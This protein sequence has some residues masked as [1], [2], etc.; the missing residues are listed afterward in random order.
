[1]G[2]GSE[3]WTIKACADVQSKNT[4][5][6]AIIKW[7]F[8]SNFFISRSLI[9]DSRLSSSIDVNIDKAAIII[10]ALMPFGRVGFGSDVTL[11]DGRNSN[12]P[13]LERQLLVPASNPAEQTEC[14]AEQPG[15]GR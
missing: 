6:V 13:L 4:E 11:G 7:I 15:D 8:S 10:S 3:Y 1:M 2:P 12:R 5:Q 9:F 14:G